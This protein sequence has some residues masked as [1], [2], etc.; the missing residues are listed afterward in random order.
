MLSVY[1]G[2]DFIDSR[3][4]TKSALSSNYPEGMAYT[5]RRRQRVTA[6]PRIWLMPADLP[7][8]LDGAIASDRDSW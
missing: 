5:S 7:I 4:N 3:G 6:L 8:V 2:G 1:E